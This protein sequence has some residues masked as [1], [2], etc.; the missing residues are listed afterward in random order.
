MSFEDCF[1][2]FVLVGWEYDGVFIDRKLVIREGLMTWE[3][4]IL[5]FRL[6][7]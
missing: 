2:F 6:I 4:V 7:V 5:V 1:E 3:T